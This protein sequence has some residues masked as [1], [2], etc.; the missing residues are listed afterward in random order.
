VVTL[1]DSG[2]DSGI[3]VTLDSAVAADSA[4][5]VGMDSGPAVD[6]AAVR[7]DT[8]LADAR[9]TARDLGSLDSGTEDLG[10]SVADGG[11]ADAR[12]DT[13][14]ADSGT[15]KLGKSSSGCSC[16]LGGANRPSAMAG[17]LLALATVLLAFT[18][19]RSGR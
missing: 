6:S 13:R 4:F 1:P 12:S 15:G 9:S 17:I 5:D 19:R 16:A 8:A 7:R 14:G 11:L 2:V 18:R 3:V 10:P